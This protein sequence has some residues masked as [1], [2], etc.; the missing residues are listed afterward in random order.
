MKPIRVL[1][2]DDHTLVL[3]GIRG[4]LT[5]LAGVEVVGEAADGHEADGHDAW[6][7]DGHVL[8]CS[9]RGAPVTLGRSRF[10][11]G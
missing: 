4:L 2:A 1:L 7:S 6:Q 5:N 10:A 11:T 3:A 9:L 8:G